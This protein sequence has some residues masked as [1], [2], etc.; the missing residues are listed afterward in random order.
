[1][2]VRIETGD[3]LDVMRAWPDCLRVNCCVTSPPYFGLRDYGTAKWEGG[4]SECN[5]VGSVM[6]TAPPGTEKQ[7]SNRGASAV[8]SGDCACGANRVDSQIGLEPTPDAYVAKL[9]EVF[10]EVR[11][12]L[13]DDGPLFA[14]VTT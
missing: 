2:S 9:V 8:T 11:R 5:H 4:D 12:V 7:A 10:R 1:M 6:R 13:A 14:Q 3:C